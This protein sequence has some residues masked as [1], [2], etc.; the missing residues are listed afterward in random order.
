MREGS[1]TARDPLQSSSHT[2]QALDPEFM[3][4]QKLTGAPDAYYNT[5]CGNKKVRVCR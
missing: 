2:R 1:R 4:A 5:D 3:M